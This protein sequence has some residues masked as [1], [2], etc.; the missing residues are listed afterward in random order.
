MDAGGEE[1][2]RR[3]T[4]GRRI[5]VAIVAAGAALGLAGLLMRGARGP[6]L[7]FKPGSL[8]IV[9]T[10]AAATGEDDAETTRFDFAVAPSSELVANLGALMT[11]RMP[12]ESGLVRAGEKLSA[13]VA[14]LAEV[15]AD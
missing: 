4:S 6:G 8:V 13:G 5:V 9:T 3:T 14:T 10:T 2:R 12:R 11:G 15:A 1:A 7:P